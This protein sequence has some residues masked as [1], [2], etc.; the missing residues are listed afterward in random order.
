MRSLKT[1][2]MAYSI[3]ADSLGNKPMSVYTVHDFDLR[4]QRSALEK[5]VRQYNDYEANK[6][7]VRE[8]CTEYAAKQDRVSQ[9]IAGVWRWALGDAPRL[10]VAMVKSR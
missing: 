6:D 10:P 4:A 1:I 2:E 7:S 8:W 3:C 5:I 9:V